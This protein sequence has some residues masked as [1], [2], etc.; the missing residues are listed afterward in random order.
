MHSSMTR[1]C[2]S[3]LLLVIAVS[4]RPGVAHEALFT[5]IRE[6]SARLEQE[7]RN[8]VLYLRRG[9]LYRLS[10]ELRPALADYARARELAPDMREIDFCIGRLWLDAGAPEP[11]I[12]A[13]NAFLG[14][15][16]AH[17]EAWLTRARAHSL[18]RQYEA[19][20]ADYTQAIA[21][22]P[23]PPPDYYLERARARES[24]GSAHLPRAIAGLDEAIRRLGPL[25]TLQSAALEMELKLKRWDAALTRLDSMSAQFT[26]R[27]SLSVRRGEILLLAGRA[28][29]ACRSFTEALAAIE[30][31]PAHVR[32]TRAM[33]ELATRARH[34][35][36]EPAGNFQ[37]RR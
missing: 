12:A 8:A 9:E 15:H 37:G 10:C 22:S 17:A 16:P 24:L 26:R 35:L 28:T 30:A 23:A 27:E 32:E 7:P 29:A 34:L 5:Q 14:F 6:L 36:T 25:V 20:T 33:L 18:A 4:P 2:P 3:L 19:A 21:L 11:A 31:L 1:I 13:L